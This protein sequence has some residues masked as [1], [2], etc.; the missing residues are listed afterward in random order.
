MQL[1]LCGG[2]G[3]DKKQKA[4]GKSFQIL[5]TEEMKLLDN[6]R[7]ISLTTMLSELTINKLN[8]CFS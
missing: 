6:K 8:I 7:R 4:K 3:W 5:R 1:C 2:H